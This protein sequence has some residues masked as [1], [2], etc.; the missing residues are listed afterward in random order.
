MGQECWWT[1]MSVKDVDDTMVVPQL[2]ILGPPPSETDKW[3]SVIKHST[4]YWSYTNICWA[5]HLNMSPKWFTMA[6]KA[7]FSAPVQTHHVLVMSYAT[8][9]EQLS[10]YT[11]IKK[12]CMHTHN[13]VAICITSS[14]YSTVSSSGPWPCYPWVYNTMYEAGWQFCEGDQT[15]AWT[16]SSSEDGQVAAR[17]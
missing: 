15:A 10:L 2:L 3:Q 1:V 11:N 13:L 4:K 7:I 5:L 8:P 6:T 17:H 14:I 12:E 9:N 16:S